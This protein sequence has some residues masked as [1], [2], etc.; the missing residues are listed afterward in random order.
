[1]GPQLYEYLV[2]L[3]RYYEVAMMQ[4][5]LRRGLLLS[6]VCVCVI[7][8]DCVVCNRLITY[9]SVPRV[10][11][12]PMVG[13]GT[14]QARVWQH[15]VRME[16]EEAVDA[17]PNSRRRRKA[18]QA[19]APPGTSSSRRSA[20]IMTTVRSVGA[21]KS[22]LHE[23]A[24][25]DGGQS[26]G[27]LSVLE[28]VPTH[29]HR[30]TTMGPAVGSAAG[31]ALQEGPDTYRGW[32]VK[33]LPWAPAPRRPGTGLSAVSSRT[34]SA[35]SSLSHV[36]SRRSA[37]SLASSVNTA[38]MNQLQLE[39]EEERRHRSAMEDELAALRQMLQ[40]A[41]SGEQRNVSSARHE[42]PIV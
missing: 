30:I 10:N 40:L 12:R 37:T 15:R 5:R 16:E 11:K 8:C 19:G 25:L 32:P 18:Q 9:G 7:L 42:L 35:L 28:R 33:A 23:P 13:P 39:L 17:W 22:A 20:E 1:M 41:L 36:S 38:R 6:L 14:Q 26:L 21:H 2:V 29:T 3:Y 4:R 24:M 27:R 34:G 31:S